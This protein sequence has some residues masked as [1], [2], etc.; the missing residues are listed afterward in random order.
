M[1]RAAWDAAFAQRDAGRK[2]WELP[3]E[4]HDALLRRPP[5]ET[6]RVSSWM[7]AT[8]IGAPVTG[9]CGRS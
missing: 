3:A 6:D 5:G 2:M 8:E 4:E 7:N 9:T 1:R